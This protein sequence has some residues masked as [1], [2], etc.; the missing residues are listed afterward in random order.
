MSSELATQPDFPPAPKLGI[1]GNLDPKKASA[2]EM[3]GL[4]LFSVRHGASN[5]MPHPV[6]PTT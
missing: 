1:D 6:A 4:Q 5:V 2:V 3:R